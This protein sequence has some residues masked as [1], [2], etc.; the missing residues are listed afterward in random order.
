[1]DTETE[2]QVMEAWYDLMESNP[3]AQER[4]RLIRSAFRQLLPKDLDSAAVAF[5]ED[6]PT[7]LAVADARIF[8][9]QVI[10]DHDGSPHAVV[11][12][13]PLD[14]ACVT[15]EAFDSTGTLPD[16]NEAAMRSWKFTWDSGSVLAFSTALRRAGWRDGP[17]LGEEVAATMAARLGWLLPGHMEG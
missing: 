14:A 5:V 7:I 3:N 10:S 15:M 1:M 13:L 16:G 6:E 12:S 17:D 4:F 9:V 2:Q 8:S 11:R